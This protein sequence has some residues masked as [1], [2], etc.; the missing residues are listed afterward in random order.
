[1]ERSDRMVCGDCL[2]SV[3]LPADDED[4]LAAGELPVLRRDDR[5]PAGR[6]SPIFQGR[7]STRCRPGAFV[8]RSEPS[9]PR[10]GPRDARDL[11][12]R[13]QLRE[14]LGGGGFGQVYR[15]YDPRLDR[16][17]ALKVLKRCATRATG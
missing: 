7:S 16:D 17:V 4:R 11:V 15:A 8:S 9:G 3:E 14:T 6:R 13:F 1:M 5:Q 10:P 2:R 12:G